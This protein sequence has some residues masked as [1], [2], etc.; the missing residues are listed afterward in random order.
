MSDINIIII[1]GST[2]R[3]RLKKIMPGLS[4]D[5]IIV[6]LQSQIVLDCV[7]GYVSIAQVW[8]QLGTGA[9]GSEVPMPE[10]IGT[11][12]AGNI[13]SGAPASGNVAS[14]LVSANSYSTMRSTRSSDY[15]YHPPSSHY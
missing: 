9:A 8:G 14:A 5:Y 13:G 7:P 4:F 6:G 12:V 3:Q 11:G 15:F 2:A 1:D 10:T